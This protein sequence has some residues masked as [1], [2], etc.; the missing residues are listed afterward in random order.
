[1]FFAL[2]LFVSSIF[3]LLFILWKLPADYFIKEDFTLKPNNINTP[4]LS[5]LWQ[6]LRNILGAIL[7]I[8]GIIMLVLPGQ[9][10][11]TIIIGLI[12]VDF[13][14]KQKLLQ[15]L[16]TNKSVQKSLNYL[17][18]KLGREAF[19]FPKAL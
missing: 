17:R 4:I 2:A 3:L 16:I 6:I 18:K 7:I 19:V 9:G 10:V 5:K 13:P 12:L 14:G 1:M 15:K 11:L 8:L